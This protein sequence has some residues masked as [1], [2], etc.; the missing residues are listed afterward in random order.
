ML[1]IVRR[2]VNRAQTALSYSVPAPVG[3]V[4]ARDSLAAM[5]PTDSIIC[6]NWFCQP[7]YLQVRN[8]SG[9]WATG[10]PSYVE[11]VMAYNGVANR[12]LFGW[13]QNKLYDATSQGAIGAA[14]ISGMT[15]SR[16]QHS[17]FNAGGGNVLL[18]VNGADSP[19][20]YDG[21][22][23]GGITTTKSLVG[24][25][26]YVNGT[27][28]NVP[29]TGG[30]GSGAQATIVVAGGAVTSVT[31]TALGSGYLVNDVLSASNS[32]LGGSGSGFPITVETVGGW[33]VTTLNGSGLTPANLITI[34]VHQQRCWFIETNTMN[35]WYTAPSA[36]QG[37]VTK[38]PLGQLFKEGGTLM[39]MASWTI[40][41]VSGINAYAA[42][43]TTEGEVAIYQGYD[44]SQAATWALVGVFKIGRPI[45]RRCL[46]KFGSD[47]LVITADGLVPLSRGLL[48]DRTQGQS[49]ALTYKIR[50]AITADIQSYA[51]NFGWQVIVHPI[52]NK[53]ILNVPEV[54]DTTSHQWVKNIV[55][56]DDGG[57]SRFRGWNATSWEVQQDSLYYGGNQTIFIADTG[58]S[59]AGN[60]ITVDCKP[61]FSYFDLPGQLKNFD[62][63]RPIFFASAVI[64]P[65][66]VALNIDF[67]D[68]VI[69]SPP[70][71]AGGTAPWD[72]SPWDVTPW[73]DTVPGIPIK[74][75]QGVSGFGYVAS[76]R[77]TMQVNG[78][79]LN[80]YSTDYLY[81]QAGPI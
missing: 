42:F 16:W 50:N 12:K 5:P 71:Q 34:T 13:S 57:W 79:A 14:I 40:D 53:L 6:D 37:T 17:M 36:Y 47:V 26:G 24:G 28:T 20:R 1:D 19:E 70:L 3:G 31:I 18:C 32:N 72:T 69:Q 29:L 9:T 45:G 33:S 7:S 66:I 61:A 52:G 48:T 8:G 54:T 35:V 67:G 25:S 22:T 81:E 73:G 74:A 11:T 77:L 55:R 44:P 75:W 64:L 15:N 68:L 65:P 21:G 63:A 43:I 78:I 80:W 10:F 23:Q 2:P 30:T 49:E 41:N 51:A 38:L 46:V 62:F 56:Q 59:D 27:Y 58:T 76:G 4:N 39:Q 60:A